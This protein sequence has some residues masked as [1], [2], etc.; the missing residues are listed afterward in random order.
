[1]EETAFKKARCCLQAVLRGGFFIARKE[2]RHVD[3]QAPGHRIGRVQVREMGR[4]DARARVRAV[5]RARALPALPVVQDSRY[6]PG[7]AERRAQRQAGAEAD[8]G[9][10]FSLVLQL[11]TPLISTRS[12]QHHTRYLRLYK[13]DD[14]L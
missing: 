5:R 6:R 8:E 10:A 1:M 4:A 12:N 13:N 7:R 9:A 3:N 14:M 2:V 11:G